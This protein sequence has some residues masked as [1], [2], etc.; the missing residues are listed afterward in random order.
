MGHI[1]ENMPFIAQ[2]LSNWCWAAAMEMV[3]KKDYPNIQQCELVTKYFNLNQNEI[4]LKCSDCNPISPHPDCNRTIKD[5]YELARYL[6]YYGYNKV[7]ISNSITIAQLREQITN[8]LPFIIIVQLSPQSYET[9]A[10]VCFGI[11][12]KNLL[13]VDPKYSFHINSGYTSGHR[14]LSLD[15]DFNN[16]KPKILYYLTNIGLQA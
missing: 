9:H 10:L 12:D 5:E 4:Q 8:N 11:V 1:I 16:K 15:N 3:M 14:L 13:C 7:E 6:K 2:K